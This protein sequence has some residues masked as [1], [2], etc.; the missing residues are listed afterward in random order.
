ML[1][2][3]NNPRLTATKSAAIRR[4][5]VVVNDGVLGRTMGLSEDEDDGAEREREG[6]S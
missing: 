4:A 6:L 1:S 3:Q 2:P 5:G